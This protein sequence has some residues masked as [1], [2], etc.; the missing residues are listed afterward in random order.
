[1][2][3]T[4]VPQHPGASAAELVEIRDSSSVRIICVGDI[5]LADRPLGYNTDTYADDILDMLAYVAKLEKALKADAV[6]WAGDIFHHKQP[7]R[8]SHATVL[9]LA[10]VA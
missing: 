10:R 9:K 2:G 6:V 7:S 3:S 8:T 4:S 1:M 5:H